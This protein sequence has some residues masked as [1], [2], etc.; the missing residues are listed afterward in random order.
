MSMIENADLNTILRNLT[1][2]LDIPESYLEQ[3]RQRYQ[4]FG[5]WLERDAS[6]V[7]QFE[8][9]I[10]PQGSFS[11]GTVTKP[12]SNQDDYDIDLVCKLELSK[13]EITQKKLK[14]L[15]GLE[16]E[17]Y[18]EAYNMQNR[19]EEKRRSWRLNYAEGAQF[20]LDVLPSVPDIF[21]QTGS[22]IAIT[23]NQRANYHYICDD[24]VC[25]DPV[26]YAEW[27]KKR[28]EVQFNIRRKEL[29]EVLKANVDDVPV[30]K[31]K[32]PL[33]RVV[34]ILKRHRDVTYEGDSED[35]PVSILITTLAAQAYENE[36]DLVE[37][38][39][40]VVTNMADYI[41]DR[42][43]VL[44]VANP[45]N[46]SENFADK[47]Q[48]YPQRQDIFLQWLNRVEIDVLEAVNALDFQTTTKSLKRQ[49][50]EF[51]INEA[52]KPVD[53]PTA[54]LA[55][56]KENTTIPTSFEVPHRQKP[57]WY[58]QLNGHS[59][60]SINA[61]VIK[62]GFRPKI[63]YNNGVKLPKHAS[64][65]FFANTDVAKPYDVYWQVV[66]TG[67]EAQ[68]VDA[69]RG[70]FYETSLIKKGKK[71]RQE[72]TLYKGTH[73]VECFIV[74]QGACVARSGEFVVNIV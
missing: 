62:N 18:V 2:F 50:G 58:M 42:N 49:F 69:L 51:A 8:P 38:L 13:K 55:I 16:L 47:W 19:P 67:E 63:H 3:A 48:E 74:K 60:V 12:I 30:Y 20:H 24:W 57:S 28:M 44:W 41:E 1:D 61:R 31:V 15:V 73:W 17:N 11:L 26:G 66:N 9:E 35:K 22:E 71:M 14:E 64:L 10:F 32:T 46:H 29:A 43:G 6:V 37:A 39:V 40:N 45:V 68:N 65:Q 7:S 34:Q 52:M 4:A 70:G 23:D 54:K 27:F 53:L 59:R 72:S 56:L 25:C 36:G 5:N 21:V 33:Q